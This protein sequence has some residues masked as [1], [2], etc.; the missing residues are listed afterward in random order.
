MVFSSQGVWEA[1]LP[2]PWL[3]TLSQINIY[4]NWKGKCMLR[5]VPLHTAHLWSVSLWVNLWR[6]L[7]PVL[8]WGADLWQ[9]SA[10]ASPWRTLGPVPSGQAHLWRASRCPGHW[11]T[12]S[13]G[14]KQNPEAGPATEG[15]KRR[16]RRRKK[17]SNSSL[18]GSV[19]LSKTI[20]IWYLDIEYVYDRWWF[21]NP[22]Q[23]PGMH[24][25]L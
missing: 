5:T 4:D 3:F 8:F 14:G 16:Q 13:N 22:Q 15:W 18:G 9:A 25:T 11:D 7:E 20:G 17:C 6:T 12:L 2:L 10:W 19:W 23:P 21:R 24:E 1:L